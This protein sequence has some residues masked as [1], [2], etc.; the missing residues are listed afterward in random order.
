MP[1]IIRYLA[2]N[3]FVAAIVIIFLGW[4]ILQ[5][6]SIILAIFVAY[7]L[8]AALLPFV[9]FLHKKKFPKVLAVLIPYFTTIALLV[10]LIFPLIPFIISQIQS[11]LEHFPTFV[12]N[13]ARLLGL[14][15][16]RKE[17]QAFITSDLNVI[18]QNAF[19]VTTKVFGG[20]FSTLT[21]L[22]V[23]FYLLIDHDNIKQ[24]IAYLFPKKRQQRV[25]DV[26]AQIE[27]KLGAWLR[28]QII[29][30]FFIGT[31]TWVVLTLIGLEFALPLAILAGI[32]EIVP[33][34][35]PILAAIPAILV[36]LSLS[37][38]IVAVIVLAYIAIQALENNFL[39]PKIMEHAVGL[40]PV[41]IILGVMIGATLMGAIGAL[42]S[43]P[44][45]A[46]LLIVYRNLEKIE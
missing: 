45:I 9:T 22:V 25:L 14:Q 37:P 26:F 18:G 31:V 7:I 35:G 40:H 44:I 39:V 17:V 21:I 15:I 38:T 19:T 11:L 46:T 30:S 42:L 2:H 28:G 10:L 1:T 24:Q 23:S 27:E 43:I 4:F 32:L 20:L 6:K 33:T 8:T 5:L 13:A 12:D 3:Q 29:L 36:A 41:V 34:I 16:N